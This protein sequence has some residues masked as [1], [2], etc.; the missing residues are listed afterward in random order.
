MS[1]HTS[2][3]Q[4][5]TIPELPEDVAVPA[6]PPLT[7]TD[8]RAFFRG[9]VITLI[10]L[11]TWDTTSGDPPAGWDN[12]TVALTNDQLTDLAGEVFD[13]L[14]ESRDL[15]HAYVTRLTHRPVG[16]VARDAVW[17]QAGADFALT[18]NRH[19]AGYWDRGLGELGEHLS[20][21][22]RAWGTRGVTAWIRDG[23]LSTALH[24]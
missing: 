24:D 20:V 13:F 21:A 23:D 10:R 1:D 11:T 6:I 14:T 16:P 18:R 4:P 19:G 17:E 5:D 7:E 3:V 2:G 15:L 22:A 9:Y 8:I 12:E